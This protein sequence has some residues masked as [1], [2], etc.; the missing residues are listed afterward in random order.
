MRLWALL[1]MSLTSGVSF[2]AEV[3]VHVVALANSESFDP[4]LPVLKYPSDDLER[5]VKVMER[6]GTVPAKNVHKLVEGTSAKLRDL[7]KHVAKEVKAA[8]PAGKGK[9]LFYFTGH[10]DANG[11]HLA[12]GLFRKEDLHALLSSVPAETR[13]ALLDSCYSGALAA[14]GIKP[15]DGFVVPQAEF[16]EPSGS[17]FLAATSGTDVAF[18]VEELK[19]SLFTHHLVAGLY[20][21]ADVNKDGLVTIDELYQFVY[22]RMAAEQSALPGRGAQK[23]EYRVDLHGRGA[24][25]LSYLDKTTE[26]VS[27]ESDLKGELTFVSDNGLQIF[28]LFK[29]QPSTVTTKLVPASYSVSLR[30]G[31]LLGQ[32]T[33]EVK[34][35]KPAS[36]AMKDFRMERRP[37]VVAVAKGQR[38]MPRYGMAFGVAVGSYL[39]P[40]PHAEVHY[41]T[42]A[43][44]IESTDWRLVG[45]LG[46]HRNALAYEE[47]RGESRTVGFLLGVNG[48]L[49]TNSLGLEGQQLHALLGGGI[50][51]FKADWTRDDDL[52]LREFDATTPKIAVGVGTS[53]LQREG[54]TLVLSVRREWPFARDRQSG[55]TLVFGNN[56]ITLS[57]EW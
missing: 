38:P 7:I 24:L 5:F 8:G 28:R 22:R 54:A 56:V 36:L 43:A 10:S 32:A 15:A 26:T 40:G 3:N 18:E 27:L 42:R 13:V 29:E 19:G 30:Q 49:L 23:P 45:I 9:F 20:G 25:I 52:P 51:Y 33:L 16:D 53:L 4:D 11:L 17:V 46:G 37:D 6:T 1:L 55:D 34:P 57:M 50:D 31:D 12:D 48:S 21:G 44:R 39:K 47:Q 41:A 35:G 2:A 14:K